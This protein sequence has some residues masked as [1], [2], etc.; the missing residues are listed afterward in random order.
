LKLEE[1]ISKNLSRKRFDHSVRTARMASHLAE[2]FGLDQDQAWTAGLAH[3]IARELDPDQCLQMAR[4]SGKNLEPE[5]QEN[6]LLLHGYCGSIIM[7]REFPWMDDAIL[8]AIC[9]H[10]TGIS[11]MGD[12]AK[13]IFIADYCEPARKHLDD[14]FCRE[15]AEGELDDACLLILQQQFSFLRER[16]RRIAKSSLLLYDELLSFKRNSKKRGQSIS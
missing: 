8:E 5:E 16:G 10:T 11:G 4:E 13:I 7:K 9:Y 6:P 15:I 1:Y 12:L 3:D 2:A 14:S